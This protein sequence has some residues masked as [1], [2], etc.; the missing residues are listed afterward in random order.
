MIYITGDTHGDFSRIERFCE[1][2]HPTSDDVMIILGDAGFN[3]Y[4]GRRDQRAKERMSQMPITIFSIHGNHE[5][6]P[7]TIPTYRLVEWHGGMV[8][9]EEAFPNLLFAMDG[10]VYDLNGLKAIVIGG[11][12]SVD[13]YYRLTMGWN[14]WADE[15]PSPEIRGKVEQVLDD[16]DWKIDVVLSHTTPLKYEPVEVFLPQIDQSKVD[17]STETWLDSIENRLTYQH[18]YAGHYHTE[19]DIDKL[20]LLFESIREF[21]A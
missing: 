10:E 13:K 6:R 18:W 8:Y 3:Y 17:K 2:V 16:H 19:K 5:M 15:Q 7:A 11:A 14:W 4:G 1:R 12:Y 21:K 9:Q 20:T